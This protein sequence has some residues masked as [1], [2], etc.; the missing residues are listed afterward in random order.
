MNKYALIES[1]EK[2]E[3]KSKKCEV[4]SKLIKA[5]PSILKIRRFC[6][7]ACKVEGQKK[8]K[9]RLNCDVCGKT[10]LRFPSEVKKSK[11][12][13]HSG[14]YCSRTCY[15]KAFADRQY[16]ENN[17]MWKGGITPENVMIRTS[18]PMITWRNEVFVRDDFTCQHCGQK[19]GKLQAHHIKPFST[20][21]DLRE[22]L[23]NG[24]TLCV[25]CHKAEHSRA[26]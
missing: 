25:D 23:D 22:D 24:I 20:H 13:G 15:F 7:M 12:R 14:K 1:L 9:H 17:P 26:A 4:C 6:S 8:E 16:G 11:A 2:H 10:F 21:P 5:P 19:G 18:K 3:G